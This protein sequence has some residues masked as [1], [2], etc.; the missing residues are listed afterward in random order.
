MDFNALMQLS[1]AVLKDWHVIF[2]AI[3]FLFSIAV[4]NYVVKYKKKPAVHTHRVAPPPPPPKEEP[5]AEGEAEE[6]KD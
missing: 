6:P 5:K 4:V 1:L 3:V 2:I